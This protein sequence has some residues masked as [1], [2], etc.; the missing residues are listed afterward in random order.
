[1]ASKSKMI[2]LG[3]RPSAAKPVQAE[4][5]PTY[6]PSPHVES[7]SELPFPKKAF[8]AK[9]KMRVKSS[10][11]LTDE[12][13]KTRHSYT[14]EVHGLHP[15]FDALE[16]DEDPAE[17]AAESAQE[18]AKENAAESLHDAMSK[19]RDRKIRQSKSD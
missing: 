3:S 13:G 7:E 17:E 1:M 10:Q 4:K 2:D 8:H 14:L 18:E 19:A 5:N 16:K 12:R 9:T 11:K 15:S 6:Y